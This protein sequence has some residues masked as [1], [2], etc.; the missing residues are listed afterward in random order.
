MFHLA[1]HFKC[2]L[3]LLQT[4]CLLTFIYFLMGNLVTGSNN[5]FHVQYTASTHS[6]LY[7]CFLALCVLCVHVCIFLAQW[8]Q[9]QRAPGLTTHP[10]LHRDCI[11]CLG[12]V[13]VR[14]RFPFPFR[15]L[16]SLKNNE[17]GDRREASQEA[18]NHHT[19]THAQPTHTHTV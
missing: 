17:A 12:E 18:V 10:S 3:P 16:V 11:S 2:K 7:V 9:E 15:T 19:H 1:C 8:H 13:E 14:R 6:S 5:C 4:R